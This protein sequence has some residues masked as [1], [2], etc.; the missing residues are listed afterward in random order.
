MPNTAPAAAAMPTARHGLL[1]TYESVVVMATRA[2]SLTVDWISPNFSRAA[3]Y[4]AC[5]L[6]RIAST[7]VAPSSLTV[8]S[9][10]CASETTFW[11]SRPTG[12]F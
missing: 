5:T 1:R 11:T 12:L 9:S 4:C 3:S 8:L 2:P 7:W 10:S 6:E